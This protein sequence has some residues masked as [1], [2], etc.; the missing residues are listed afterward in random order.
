MRGKNLKNKNSKNKLKSFKPQK[1]GLNFVKSNQVVFKFWLNKKPKIFFKLQKLKKRYWRKLHNYEIIKLWWKKRR[2][3]GKTDGRYSKIQRFYVRLFY[4]KKLKRRNKNYNARKKRKLVTIRRWYYRVKLKKK[5]KKKKLFLKRIKL[6]LK[7]KNKLFLKKEKFIFLKKKSVLK[8]K[9]KLIVFFKF[10]FK[11]KL[12]LKKKRLLLKK[13][14]LFLK[15]WDNLIISLKEKE[16]VLKKEWSSL[17]EK[18][19]NLGLLLKKEVLKFVFRRKKLYCAKLIRRGAVK[20]FFKDLKRLRR[21]RLL[22]LHFMRKLKL[23]Y[24]LKKLYS[25][26][27]NKFNAVKNKNVKLIYKK[28]LEVVKQLRLKIN[29]KYKFIKRFVVMKKKKHSFK[30][31]KLESKYSFKSILESI[32]RRNFNLPDYVINRLARMEFKYYK[33]IS[34]MKKQNIEL[35]K[36]S[37]ELAKPLKPS[38]K[39]IKLKKKKTNIIEVK[40]NNKLENKVLKFENKWRKVFNKFNFGLETKFKKLVNIS[41][42]IR[43]GM[44]HKLKKSWRGEFGMSLFFTLFVCCF[45]KLGNRTRAENIFKRVLMWLKLKLKSKSVKE[46]KWLIFK[47]FTRFRPLAGIRLKVIAGVTYRLPRNVRL[48]SEYSII[49]HWFVKSVLKRKEHGLCN[50]IIGELM[51]FLKHKGGT[52]KK[53]IDFKWVLRNSKTK[54]KYLRKKRKT[55]KP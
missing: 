1:L 10:F 32:K 54:L 3:S 2:F 23:K 11:K 47:K 37:V 9:K 38:V 34:K 43:L 31:Q 13:K 4:I 30:K 6:F 14:G 25:V 53:R 42:R 8:H 33:H 29:V 16:Y 20:L 50:K 7:V 46:I 52:I 55:I 18:N 5:F 22:K 40:K 36:P 21:I 17:K 35:I 39:I 45:V 51:D 28:Y 48:S 26:F 24:K 27:I 15:N 44:E 19:K 49:L 12:I 41:R